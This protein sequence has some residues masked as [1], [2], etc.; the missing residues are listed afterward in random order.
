MDDPAHELAQ[1]W[2]QRYRSSKRLWSGTVN[3]AVEAM[4]ARLEPGTALDLGCGEGGDALW[5]A[6]QGWRATGV[7]ISQVAIQRATEAAQARGFG[8]ERAR[9]VTADIM[10]WQPQTQFDLVVAAFFQSH[11]AFDRVAALQTA[12]SHVAPGGFML[13]I[14]HAAFPPWASAHHEHDDDPTEDEHEFTTVE[15]ELEA[16]QLNPAQWTVEVAEI[17]PRQATGAEG[18]QATLNDTIILARRTASA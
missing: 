11:G 5:L 2:D 16:L 1:Q 17:Q 14:S 18:Q 4:A 6:Q 3:A 12:A 8:E 15:S 7:D 9:F 13:T 10:T